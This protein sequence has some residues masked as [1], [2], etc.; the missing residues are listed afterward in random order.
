MNVKMQTALVIDDNIDS[1]RICEL[2]LGSLGYEVL[3]MQDSQSGANLLKQQS[4]NLLALD[5]QMPGMSGHDVLKQVRATPLH[6]DMKVMV[7]TAQAHMATEEIYERADCVLQ[8][9]LDVATFAQLARRLTGLPGTGPLSRQKHVLVIDDDDNTQTLI[10]VMLKRD[11]YHVE[12]AINAQQALAALERHTP[13]LIILD[14]ALPGMNGLELCKLIRERP[15]TQKTPVLVVTASA[16][17]V[18]ESE[19]LRLG[20]NA[21]VAKPILPNILLEKARSLMPA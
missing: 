20:A 10:R 21:F 12:A 6:T 4:F 14:L 13:D 9:P 16:D 7:M 19:S 11:G 5:L 8:K 2:V 17:S 15:A 18:S 3:V 1:C